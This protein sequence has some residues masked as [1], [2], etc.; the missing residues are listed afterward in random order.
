MRVEVGDKVYIP[1]EKKPYRVRARDERYI[2]CTKPYNPK[3]TVLYFIIDLGNKW[4]APDNRV[5][6]SGY[7]S[8][9]D[10]IERLHELQRGNLQLSSRRG[11]KL[12]IDV[13]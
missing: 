10:C 3:H 12:D 4:R 13:E 2:I 11:V 5:F 7:E 6:C 9:E 8:D 1:N